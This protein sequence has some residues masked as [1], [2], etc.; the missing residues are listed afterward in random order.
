MVA[1]A[2]VLDLLVAV[3]LEVVVLVQHIQTHKQLQEL[4]TLVAA[5]AVDQ[6]VLVQE[7]VKAVEVV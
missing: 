4:Q 6:L 2:E 1:E 5:V 3:A 7:M